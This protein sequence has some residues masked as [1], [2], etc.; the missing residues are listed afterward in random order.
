MILYTRCN[1][2]RKDITIFSWTSNKNNLRRRKGKQIKLVCK[3]CGHRDEYYISKVKAMESR[4]TLLI[5]FL[6]FL[7]GV[8]YLLYL[9]WSYL[10]LDEF[11]DTTELNLRVI[12]NSLII[13]SILFGIFSFIWCWEVNRASNF[14]KSQVKYLD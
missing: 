14:N 7:V 13:G 11:S 5:L 10:V 2:C 4:K 12:E 6:I 1:H 8:P 9:Y 3:R